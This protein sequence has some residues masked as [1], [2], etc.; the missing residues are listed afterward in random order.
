MNRARRSDEHE[1]HIRADAHA[2]ALGF[3]HPDIHRLRARVVNLDNSG[4]RESRKPR[5]SPLLH[6]SREAL[7]EM[8]APSFAE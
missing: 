6:T 1:R 8:T 7:D 3:V 4:A 2:E 5:L